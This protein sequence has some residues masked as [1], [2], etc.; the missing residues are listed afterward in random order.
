VGIEGGDG[1]RGTGT[2]TGRGRGDVVEGANCT[3]F[4]ARKSLL[5]SVSARIAACDCS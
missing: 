2:G 4:L 1:D 3:E 5:T